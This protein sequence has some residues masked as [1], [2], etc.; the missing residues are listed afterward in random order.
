MAAK[1][2]IETIEADF[3]LELYQGITYSREFQYFDETNTPIDLT[4]K[5]ISIK[6]KD[7]FPTQL[8]LFS[9]LPASVLGSDL[10]IV[11]AID[12]KFRLKLTE[13]ETTTARLGTAG[14]YWIELYDGDDIDVLW[15]DGVC[16]TEV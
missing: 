16:V 13:D 1:R 11:D 15:I 4:G 2:L 9:N 10:T 6:I 12:G 3:P 8:N 7:V 5:I 14:K